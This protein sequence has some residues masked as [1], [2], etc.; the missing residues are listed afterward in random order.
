[1]LSDSA[2]LLPTCRRAELLKAVDGTVRDPECFGQ[3]DYSQPS[4]SEN[5]D[6]DGDHVLRL[7]AETSVRS[8]YLSLNLA[9]NQFFLGLRRF[10][11]ADPLRGLCNIDVVDFDLAKLLALCPQVTLEMKDLLLKEIAEHIGFSYFDQHPL[12]IVS[13]KTSDS[14]RERQANL[15][16]LEP[17]RHLDRVR[18]NERILAASYHSDASESLTHYDFGE[19]VALSVVIGKVSRILDYDPDTSRRFQKFCAR[20]PDRIVAGSVFATKQV[21]GDFVV[22]IPR[23]GQRSTLSKSDNESINRQLGDLSSSLSDDPDDLLALEQTYRIR[24][25]AAVNTR[26]PRDFLKALTSTRD[27]T[28]DF[29]ASPRKASRDEAQGSVVAGVELPLF[30]G[31]RRCIGKNG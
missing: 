13:D 26:L 16:L 27:A 17:R 18:T 30:Q 24:Q 20:E 31:G 28:E 2:F 12:L 5:L 1:M 14:G 22:P 6:G 21:D 23:L 7:D 9:T 29:Q 25:E 10:D 15:H 4:G 19:P 3:S 8:S 11:R